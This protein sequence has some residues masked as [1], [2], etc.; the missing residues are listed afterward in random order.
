[1]GDYWRTTFDRRIYPGSSSTS[2]AA[3]ATRP[4][5]T[6]KQFDDFGQEV[7]NQE[8]THERIERFT[9]GWR[10]FTAED[11]IETYNASGRLLS[12]TDR[13]GQTQSLTYSD[14]ATPL[15]IAPYPGL[16]LRVTNQF[17]RKLSFTYDSEGRLTTMTDPAG[18]GYQ[19]AYDGNSNLIR[20]VYPS[21]GTGT[22]T[23]YY[24]YENG[25]FPHALTGITDENGSRF[26][27]YRYDTTGRVLSTEHAGAVN[28][29]SFAYNPDNTTT[30]T[31][32]L[33]AIRIYGF[34]VIN[35][36]MRNTGLSQPCAT[37]GG[38][39]A[40]ETTYDAAGF[41]ASRTDFGGTVTT[42][43]HN[44]RGLE[45]SRTEAASTSAERT[46][47]TDWHPDFRLPVRIDEPPASNRLSSVAGPTPKT[48]TYDA[49]G[50]LA[51]ET[52][53]SYIYDGRHRLTQ[54]TYSAG[55]NSYL[56][57][58][59]GQRLLK[60]GT[61][62][63]SAVRF[64]YDEAGHLIGEYNGSGGLVRETVYLGDMPV[65]LLQPTAIR[66]IYT[67]HLNTPRV[68]TDTANRFLWRWD[69]NPFGNTLPSEDFDANSVKFSYNLRFPG[70]YYDQETGLHYNYFRDY[71]PGIGRY[72]ESDP[73][74]LDGGVNTYG[75][76]LQSPMSYTDPGG[77]QVAIPLPGSSAFVTAGE[78]I[79]TVCVTNPVACAAIFASGGTGYGIGSLIY[80]HVAEPLANAIDA[81]CRDDPTAEECEEEWERAFE[82]CEREIA[83][84]NHPGITG[85]YTNLFDCAGGLVSQRCGGNKVE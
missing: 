47:T 53:R 20:V 48:F 41:I 33:G 67:D 30:V 19:Y 64:V 40:A 22:F 45:I 31:D 5:G 21:T 3:I 12:I 63:A 58:G 1:M 17:G 51:A 6:I 8:G 35:D 68:I 7:L 65:A 18:R 80:P 49:A 62:T 57:N 69:S 52:G 78:G 56:I 42:F 27:T 72:I 32:P 10:Y 16:L 11:E 14:S 74:G 66:Y 54:V 24:H 44:D 46:I 70:Q 55:S 43:M 13:A 36:V 83:T 28:K 25:A 60:T 79:L 77:L 81:V 15:S 84:G 82:I 26:A 61:G 38:T 39:A 4:D 76:A 23:R 50:N 37:C 34:N 2:S 73:I 9:G 59:L 29:Y 85:G 71:D 75:Y